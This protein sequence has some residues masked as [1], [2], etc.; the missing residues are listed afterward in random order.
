MDDCTRWLPQEMVNSV[1]EELDHTSLMRAACIARRWR[2]GAKTCKEYYL[3]LRL[4]YIVV[5]WPRVS[6]MSWLARA[7]LGSNA[8]ASPLHIILDSD[9]LEE[10]EELP[11]ASECEDFET[12]VG[13]VATLINQNM[14]LVKHLTI[15]CLPDSAANLFLQAFTNPAPLLQSLTIRYED[16]DALHQIP[17]DL[18]GGHAPCLTELY[19]AN[20]ELLS[21]PLVPAL[22]QATTVTLDEPPVDTF[23]CTPVGVLGACPNVT[24][25][26]LVVRRRPL[27]VHEKLTVPPTLRSVRLGTGLP[28]EDVKPVLDA[29]VVPSVAHAFFDAQANLL[30]DRNIS[31]HPYFTGVGPLACLVIDVEPQML[32]DDG[33]DVHVLCAVGTEGHMERV[34]SSIEDVRLLGPAV[35]HFDVLADQLARIC[36]PIQLLGDLVS[37]VNELPVLANLDLAISSNV[38]WAVSQAE[39]RQRAARPRVLCPALRQVRL[40]SDVKESNGDGPSVVIAAEKIFQFSLDIGLLSLRAPL[41]PE[42]LVEWDVSVQGAQTTRYFSAFSQVQYL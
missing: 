7:V 5:E 39:T 20:A 6:N 12:S 19:I 29:L 32:G 37:A 1:L 30:V 25:L 21:L 16:D 11:S 2:E 33:P 42:L 35:A 18:F 3:T 31:L 40:R 34:F 9:S 28:A 8:D 23:M 14:H 27:A 41:R 10:E 38:F 4:C 17:E 22:Q 36:A 13:I 26:T 24:T 15:E